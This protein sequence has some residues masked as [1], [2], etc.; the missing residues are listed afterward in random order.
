MGIDCLSSLA[1]WGIIFIGVRYK[2]NAYGY[3]CNNNLLFLVLFTCFV[4]M[5]IAQGAVLFFEFDE[6]AMRFTG[7]MPIFAT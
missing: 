6:H 5:V 4:S 2:Y 7:K 3:K 1:V